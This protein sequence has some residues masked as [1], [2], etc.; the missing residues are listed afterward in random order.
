MSKAKLKPQKE[1]CPD[2]G[3][4]ISRGFLDRHAITHSA[5]YLAA[6]AE[7]TGAAREEPASF[8]QIKPMAQRP[9]W[10]FCSGC[11]SGFAGDNGESCPRGHG[12]EQ[13]LS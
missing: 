13:T 2:C 12:R 8:V 4:M 9:G 6:K 11:M 10:Y 1:A 7:K 5:A 3:R